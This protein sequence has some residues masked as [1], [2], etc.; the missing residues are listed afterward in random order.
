M[1]FRCE[2]LEV[3][4]SSLF[5]EKTNVFIAQARGVS[6]QSTQGLISDDTHSDTV[7]SVRAA[8]GAAAARGSGAVRVWLAHRQRGACPEGR[9]KTLALDSSTA[10]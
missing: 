2:N 4:L 3:I 6:R 1:F 7:I 8:R 9:R 5:E 10:G